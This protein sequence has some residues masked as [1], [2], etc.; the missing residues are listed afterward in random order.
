MKAWGSRLR[1]LSA[2]AV[3]AAS[4]VLKAASAQPQAVAAS[5][6]L[7]AE[8][9]ESCVRNLKVIYDAIQSYQYDHKDLP[10]W[11][12]DLVPDYIS[13]P[14]VLICPVCRRT[15]RTETAALA[16]PKLACSYLYEFSPTPVGAV[17]SGQTPHT[18]REWKRR[19]MGLVGSGVPIVRCRHHN[20]ML[21]L[22][23]NGNVYESSAQWELN[24]TNRI[25][26]EELTVRSVFG[27]QDTGQE[28]PELPAPVTREIVNRTPDPAVPGHWIDLSGFYTA[29]LDED[30][31]GIPGDDLGSLP[32]GLQSFGGIEFNLRGIIQLRGKQPVLERFPPEVKGIPIHKRCQHLYFLHAASFGDNAEEGQQ[33]GS[34]IV[35]LSKNQMTLEIPI[36]YGRSVRNWH[37]SANEPEADKGLK[38]AWTGENAAS[39]RN[40]R[41]IR[42]FVTAWNLAPGVDIDTLDFVSTGRRAVPFL[43]AITID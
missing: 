36:Y 27:E 7:E 32:K 26:P 28:T 13:D 5:S 11:L 18:R 43:L 14:N 15:G 22:A 40:G 23:F 24:F 16:D 38:V 37:E 41:Q 17:V 20:P 19:Q 21:N 10:N 2:V 35:H 12:S 39:K 9:K 8:E 30:W 34:Y 25:K 6:G 33:I 3:L 1:D 4:L 29:T 42:L 31:Q